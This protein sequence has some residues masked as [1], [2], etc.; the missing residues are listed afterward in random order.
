MPAS[1]PRRL[2][3]PLN[4]SI[5]S[6]F[7]IRQ[8]PFEMDFSATASLPIGFSSLFLLTEVYIRH[9]ESSRRR[10]ISLLSNCWYIAVNTGLWICCLVLSIVA[11]VL[12]I[13]AV[14]LSSCQLAWMQA[15]VL[16]ASD[17]QLWQP[18]ADQLQ[19]YHL[20]ILL[21][22]PGESSWPYGVLALVLTACL[23]CA[24]A[25]LCVWDAAPG[26]TPHLTR[27]ALVPILHVGWGLHYTVFLLWILRICSLKGNDLRH[28][29]KW[30]V[31]CLLVAPLFISALVGATPLTLWYPPKITF[32]FWC[33]K[34]Q[35]RWRMLGER[36]AV[37]SLRSVS[38]TVRAQPTS[39][40]Y[41]AA[42]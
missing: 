7:V 24:A 19:V 40:P 42:L 13:E 18:S 32:L 22:L 39:H 25:G 10:D 2:R 37:Q 31:W 5:H 38:S 17:A 14:S 8:L 12:R 35:M 20:R 28:I 1:D 41:P 6:P 21:F 30:R 23:Q 11:L 34:Q 26:L 4:P 16:K 33:R 36:G 29:W 3:S 15:A 27:S 9:V